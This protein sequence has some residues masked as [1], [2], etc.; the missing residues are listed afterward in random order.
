[1]TGKI[2]ILLL[3]LINSRRRSLEQTQAT[4][5]TIYRFVLQNSKNFTSPHFQKISNAD[6]GMLF[7][8]T[9]EAI[10][11]GLLGQ[12]CERSSARPLS[13]RLSTRM[14][15]CGGMTTMQRENR[16]GALP[17]FEIAIATSPLFDTFKVDASAKVGGIECRNRLQALQRIME[18]EMLHLA[19]LLLFADSNCSG[20]QF[21]SYAWRH[22][23]HTESNHRLLTPR[24]VAKKK[25]GI[26]L[27]DT[28]VFIAEGKQ[29]TGVVNRI[30]KRATVLVAD[31]GGTKYTDGKRYSK[32]YVP[33]NMLRRK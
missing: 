6:L 22:F 2:E 18:H 7:Q 23:G 8:I 20:P 31:P 19:E 10:F 4:Q 9:D 17:E 21:K 30:T 32:F 5:Q 15:S 26:S 24:D 13:F 14:T 12:L 27:G 16:P 1:M 25:L 28:V 11:D 33:L 29:F 3:K